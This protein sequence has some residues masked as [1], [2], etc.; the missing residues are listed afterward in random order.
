MAARA[1]AVSPRAV[2][3]AA[4]AGGGAAPPP[5]VVQYVVLR[6]DLWRGLGWPL[7][8]VAAQACHAATAALWLSREDEVTRRYCEGPALD[9]MHKVVLEVK[10]EQQ[11]VNLSEKLK[12]S[13]VV[14][15]LWMEQPENIPTCLATKPYAKDDVAVLFK[16]YNL[17]KDPIGPK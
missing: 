16:K 12:D 15:K 14:H 17:C 9:A 11:L 10:S 8:A 1:A 6:R 7:G 4:A 13:G 2:A 5:P 3:A